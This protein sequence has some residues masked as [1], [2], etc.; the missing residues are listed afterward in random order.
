[1]IN[2]QPHKILLM[3]IVA[4]CLTLA[5]CTSTPSSQ[6]DSGMSQQS[7][8]QS[9]EQSTALAATNP[10]AKV[11]LIEAQ[12]VLIRR[13]K[14]AQDVQAKTGMG[15]QVSD[16][17]RTLAP[18]RVQVEFTNGV[19][20]RIGGNSILKI[21]PQ[22]RLNFTKG[23]MITWVKPGM[24]VP[25]EIVTP[26]AIASIRGTTAYVEI[27]PDYKSSSSKGIRFFSWEGNVAVRLTNSTEE[28]ILKTGE[29]VFIKPGA[30]TIPPVYR[31]NSQEWP[32]RIQTGRFLRSFKTPLPTQPIIDQ[33]VPGQ[34]SPDEPAPKQ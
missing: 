33:L 32:N 1:M 8:G 11:V 26:V 7:T 20:F 4:V 16:T 12:K 5:S 27:P 13:D 25:T 14:S 24:K 6:T 17:V 15:L 34:S 9:T 21:Q 31:L 30:K 19:S 28:V 22:N 23:D 18:G 29:E 2:S 10:P 3:P